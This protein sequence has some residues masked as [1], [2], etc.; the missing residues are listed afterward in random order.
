MKRISYLYLLAADQGYRLVHT[1]DSGLAE[2][3]QAAAD[4]TILPQHKDG[5]SS[6]EELQ[7]ADMA[8]LATAALA[9]EWA[10]GGY[11]RIVIAT[12]PR[13]LGLVRDALPKA[14]TPH[15]AAEFHKDLLKI[16]LHDL[17]AHFDELPMI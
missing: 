11:D 15:V 2:I 14:L 1:R 3:A 6:R 12:G 4:A 13:M 9:A 7:H 17:G 10:K 8:R 5:H 16:P